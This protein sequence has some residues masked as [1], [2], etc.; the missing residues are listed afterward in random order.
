[1]HILTKVESG[2]VT[3]LSALVIFGIIADFG[4]DYFASR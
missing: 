2:K 4:K 3:N 1:M